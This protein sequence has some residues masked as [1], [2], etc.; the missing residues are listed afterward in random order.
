MRQAHWTGDQPLCDLLVCNTSKNDAIEENRCAPHVIPHAPRHGEDRLVVLR[1]SLVCLHPA[2]SKGAHCSSNSATSSP[3]I[4]ARLFL[5]ERE[6]RSRL[7]G[8]CAMVVG[9]GSVHLCAGR[10][11]EL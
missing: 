4:F 10:A 3:S 7:L 2:S 6:F 9:V 5:G 1:S 8:A 11:K